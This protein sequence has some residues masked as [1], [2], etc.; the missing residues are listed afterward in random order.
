MRFASIILV[1][2]DYYVVCLSVC[3]L[4]IFF[5]LIPLVESQIGRQRF[6]LMLRTCLQMGANLGRGCCGYKKY[7]Q[8]PP[9]RETVRIG[10]SPEGT[11][12]VGSQGS[13]INSAS[14]NTKYIFTGNPQELTLQKGE[15]RK[16]PGVPSLRFSS[17]AGPLWVLSIKLLTYIVEFVET[18]LELLALLIFI[19]IGAYPNRP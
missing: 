9:P 5:I 15:L 17:H 2:I 3:W 7:K 6:L 18:Y 12:R 10:L 13:K 19:K 4:I 11:L 16:R 14:S 8:A 1:V